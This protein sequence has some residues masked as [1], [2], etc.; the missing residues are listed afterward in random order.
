MKKG[1]LVILYGLYTCLHVFANGDTLHISH[2]FT[3]ADLS[4]YAWV[5]NQSTQQLEKWTQRSLNFGIYNDQIEL[6]FFL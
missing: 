3:H 6:H 2:D 4:Q 5:K 1:F